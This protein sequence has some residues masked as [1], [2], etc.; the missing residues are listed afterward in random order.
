[1]NI[2]SQFKGIF[3]KKY[4]IEIRAMLIRFLLSFVSA[5][6]VMRQHEH[7]CK[8]RYNKLQ[9]EILVWSKFQDRSPMTCS[10][11]SLIIYTFT[12]E[13]SATSLYIRVFHLFQR[14]SIPLSFHYYVKVSSQSYVTS[15]LNRFFTLMCLSNTI[16][17]IIVLLIVILFQNI[18]SFWFLYLSFQCTLIIRDH[19]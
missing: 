17:C 13:T 7:V 6:S 11:A 1:M 3:F 18:N 9:K 8:R 12:T 2:S 16:D 10:L 4:H 15:P 19:I 5:P 14:L